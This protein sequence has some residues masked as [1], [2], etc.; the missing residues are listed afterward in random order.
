[1]SNHNKDTAFSIHCD[2]LFAQV[3]LC[4][5]D[6]PH[7]LVVCLRAVA[8]CQDVVANVSERVGSKRNENP[9]RKDRQDFVRY[10]LRHDR[11][12]AKEKGKV[13]KR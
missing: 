9:K 3:V 6:F 10:H 8:K 5:L 1:M 12:G 7:E 13:D 2:A 11:Y 4:L